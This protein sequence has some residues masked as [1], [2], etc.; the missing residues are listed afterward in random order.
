MLIQTLR[1]YLRGS[2]KWRSIIWI[3]AAAPWTGGVLIRG[4]VLELGSWYGWV[5]EKIHAARAL[6]PRKGAV[7]PF[8]QSQVQ[9][10]EGHVSRPKGKMVWEEPQPLF[11][12]AFQ[13]S[14]QFAII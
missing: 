8:T 3:I 5:F 11:V 4:V 7:P 13:S 2:V 1:F 10:L 9:A 12:V 14:G 6:R